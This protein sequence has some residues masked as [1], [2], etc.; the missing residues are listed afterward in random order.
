[1]VVAERREHAAERRGA[2]HVGVAE[3]VAAAVHAGALAVPEPEDTVD[4]ALAAQ[5]R[6]LTAPEGGGGEILVETR[7]ELD[8]RG[9]ELALR[10]HHLQVEATER[11]AAVAGGIARGGEPRGLVARLL[12]QEHA[13]QR[14][15][16][17]EQHLPL[18]QVEPVCERDVVQHP[19]SS[20]RR[21]A[22]WVAP[23]SNLGRKRRGMKQN[24]RNMTNAPHMERKYPSAAAA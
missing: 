14:L 24:H 9:R 2:G 20:F 6:L 3:D 1:M 16:A 18:G 13:H 10:T 11:R 4:A 17:A 5:R 15:G 12:H 23:P 19:A 7:L 8:V 21:R 22:G